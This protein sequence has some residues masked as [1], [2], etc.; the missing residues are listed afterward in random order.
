MGPTEALD[1]AI[2]ASFADMAFMDAVEEPAPETSVPPGQIVHIDFAHPLVGCVTLHLP[3]STK[4]R[5][6]ENIYGYG[7][8]SLAGSEVDDCLMELVNV[9]AGNFL[10]LMGQ[11]EHRHAVSLP[12]ILYDDSDIPPGE[13][14]TRYYRVDDELTRVELI[15]AV[16]P[17]T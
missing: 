5:L 6:V 10:R 8:E 4:K 3:A 17:T 15:Y 2:V 16:P 1:E 14:L 11:D 12:Q 9:V 7:W 13:R